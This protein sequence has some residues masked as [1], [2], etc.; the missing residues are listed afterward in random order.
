MERA[1]ELWEE[2]GLPQLNPESPWHGYSLGDWTEEWD[3]LAE[4]AAEG[5]YLEN[6]KRSAQRRRFG[7]KPNTHVRSVPNWDKDQD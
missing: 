1:K 6:G 3:R 2:L 4:R 5:D 7:V